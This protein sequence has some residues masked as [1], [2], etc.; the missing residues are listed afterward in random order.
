MYYGR[1]KLG[2]EWTVCGCFALG[3]LAGTALLVQP[4]CNARGDSTPVLT[5]LFTATS[6]VCVTGLTVED[7]ATF[8]SPAGQWV[9]LG[10]VQAGGLGIMTMGTFLIA[11]LGGRLSVRDEFVLMDSLGHNSARGLRSVLAHAVL[12][13]LA[14]EGIGAAYLAF[15]FRVAYGFEW[16]RAVSVGIFHAV[17]A[18]C[19]AGFSTFS[20]SLAMFRTDR[21]VLLA[22]M[23]LIVAGGLG[24]TVLHNIRAMVI[25]RRD[26]LRPPRLT[27]HSRLVIQT[28]VG[29]VA[30][31]AGVILLLEWDRWLGELEWP[32][33]VVN[34]MFMAVTPRTAGF[35]VAPLSNLCPL[36]VYTVLLLMIVGGSPASTA[37]GIKTTTF[38]VLAAATRALLRGDREVV[39]EN[40]EISHISVLKAVAVFTVAVSLQALFYAMILAVEGTASG[41]GDLLFESISAFG[42]VG[43]S[44]GVTPTLSALGKIV[45]M[46]TMFVGRLLSLVISL[47]VGAQVDRDAVQ[48]PVE[49]VLVG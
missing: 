9:I 38:A 34:A 14:F 33:K 45:I 2:T 48:Y 26:P 41:A 27:L 46:A 32:D 43:L 36:S 24:F 5:A 42:T 18:F 10:L 23:I 21:G 44:T 17:S 6:A 25:G 19:N 15:H 13:T 31:G 40:R 4:F 22:M 1:G 29:L 16:S 8:F 47:R 49:D 39:C 11:L 3:I 28:T 12:M 35:A 7:T 37:G 20:D 30:I